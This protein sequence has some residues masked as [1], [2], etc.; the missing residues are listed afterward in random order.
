MFR[1]MRMTALALIVLCA[2]GGAVL[3]QD[4]EKPQAQFQGKVNV[5]E[6][7]L[8]VLVSD[9]KGNVIVGLDKNDFV[10][11]E[12]GKPVT[13]TGVTFYS[14][15]RLLQ[16]TPT[17]AKQGVS[18]E[19]TPEDRYFVLFFEDQK[20]NAQDAPQLLSQQMEAAKRA[21]GWVDAELL[22]NDWVAVVSY[23]TRLKVQQ[24]FTHDQRALVAAIGD[25]MQ[26]KDPEGNYPS[27]IQPGKGPS[28]L[29]GL[30]TGSEL[31]NK[32]P[33]IYEALQQVARAAGN[34]RGRKNLLLFTFGL[35]GRENT[36]GS[37]VP[38]DRYFN[39]TVRALNDNNVAVYSLDLTPAA[40]EHTLSDSLN[41]LAKDT[42]GRYF[43]NVTNFSTPLDQ[44]AKENNG[45]YLLS[46]ESTQPA[47][48]SG[49]QEVDV[50]TTNPEFRVKARKGYDYG[51]D[52]AK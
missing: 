32:T 49:F 22:P 10:V 30:P 46:Y 11:K 19:Q 18:V 21:R 44:V 43:F 13:L 36:F 26:G 23:D 31:R 3:A 9:A 4:Q 17:L 35:P 51:K 39:P 14:N 33:T 34:V 12:N 29:A 50:K 8:D 16:S 38:D 24:D 5:N 40:V 45:Y 2:F 20:A 42:G 27:R 28:L 52:L 7:L 47:G 41:L 48:K 15:R 25:A 6:V 1:I 37:Y